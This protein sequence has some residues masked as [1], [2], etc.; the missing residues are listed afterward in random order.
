MRFM[1]IDN[2]LIINVSLPNIKSPKLA[3]SEQATM[4]SEKTP[5]LTIWNDR[6]IQQ[7][8]HRNRENRKNG[9][10]L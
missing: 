9:Y 1:N 2:L 8:G 6:D 7:M 10:R 3:Y 4:M 5:V